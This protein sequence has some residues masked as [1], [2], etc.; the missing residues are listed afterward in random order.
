[1]SST[2]CGWIR[3]NEISGLTFASSPDCFFLYFF[4]APCS[5]T[6]TDDEFAEH[7]TW[8]APFLT[9]LFC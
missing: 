7:V 3:E 9:V 4:P 8:I 6:E 2:I 5:T 1:M